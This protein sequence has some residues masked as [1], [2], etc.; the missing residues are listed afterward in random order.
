MVDKSKLPKFSPDA[1]VK[2]P[3]NNLVVYSIYY[4]YDQGATVASED[5]ILACFLLFPKRFSLRT[6]PRWPDSAVVMRRWSDCRNR[7][8]IVG[9]PAKGFK[10]TAK[11][12]RFA[13]KV[14]KKL[15]VVKPARVVKARHPEKPAKK[16]PPV[17]VKKARQIT[18]TEKH[19]RTV[20]RKKRPVRVRPQE[21]K[22]DS[23]QAV[24]VKTIPPPQVKEVR[25]QQGVLPLH[26]EKTPP[27]PGSVPKEVKVR[28]GKFVH[29][30]ER[31]DAYVDFKRNGSN[32]KFGEFDFRSMLLC[33]MESS[34][35]ALKNNIR[36][37]KEYAG[38]H[39]R[40]D[41]LTFLNFC[42]DR[43]SHLLGAS[44]KRPEKKTRK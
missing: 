30:M 15:G 17:P 21:K 32:S 43:F 9:S 24:P 10:L 3:L 16:H 4:L 38:I 44:L 41:L 29:M 33:T 5:I 11:G 6:Y 7:G 40:Q 42:E 1:Y 31:S 22:A 12:I 36:L 19:P 2:I 23:A 13:E 18:Q 25:F 35:I 14:G 37:F 39:N 8:Y 20:V 34:S 27:V 28:A 26:V